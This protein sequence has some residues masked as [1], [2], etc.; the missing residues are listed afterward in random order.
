MFSEFQRSVIIAQGTLQ[1][2]I[3]IV[4]FTVD[5]IIN[6]LNHLKN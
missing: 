2:M 1:T 6:R 3:E 5:F 4:L